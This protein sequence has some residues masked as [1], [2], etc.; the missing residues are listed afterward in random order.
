MDASMNS[1]WPRPEDCK[2]FGMQGCWNQRW[3]HPSKDLGIRMFTR[4]S[5]KRRRGSALDW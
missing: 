5:N 4:L 1:F 2:E 3:R